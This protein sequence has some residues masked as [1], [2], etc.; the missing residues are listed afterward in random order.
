MIARVAAEAT[1]DRHLRRARK[2]RLRAVL[3]YPRVVGVIAATLLATSALAAPGDAAARSVCFGHRATIVG[4]KHGNHIRGT[5]H[6]DV[7]VAKGG[8]DVIRGNGG[9]DVICGGGGGDRIYGGSQ[10]NR[11]RRDRPTQLIGGSGSDRIDGGFS[12]DFIVGDAANKRS[13]AK[14]HVGHDRLDGDFGNDYIVGDNFSRFNAR[15]GKHDALLGQKGNDTIIGD[16]AVTGHGTAR[17]GGNDHFESMSDKDFEVGDSFSP[18]GKAAGGG[19]DELN[20]GPQRDLIVG[21]SFTRTGLAVGAGR[22]Q[23]HARPGPD[24]AYGDNRAARRQGRA[25]GGKHD[26]IGGAGGVDHL[27]GGPARDTCNGGHSHRDTAR[28][29]EYVLEV[30]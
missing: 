18:H 20:A 9:R 24:R 5:R 30:P 14:G 26:F 12:N 4:N 17:G 27:F 8:R 3:P 28:Q 11:L 15:G 1:R 21:D 19:N 29:C 16:S 22:D 23:I 6:A 7:I 13:N 2:A 25:R 10:P